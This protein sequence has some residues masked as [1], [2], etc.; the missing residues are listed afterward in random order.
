M[1]PRPYG[2]P[3]SSETVTTHRGH[4]R[5]AG[6]EK[7]VKHY[8]DKDDHWQFSWKDELQEVEKVDLN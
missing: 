7:E 8:D 5:A 2:G 3:G 4:S 1:H 6:Q